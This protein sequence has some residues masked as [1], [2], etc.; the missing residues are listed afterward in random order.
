MPEPELF[1]L[2][3]R[4]LNGAGIRVAQPEAEMGANPPLFEVPPGA[5]G[6]LRVAYAKHAGDPAWT[7]FIRRIEAESPKFAQNWAA[8]DVAPPG[9]YSKALRHPGLGEFMA[10]TTTFAVQSIPGTRMTVYTPADPVSRITMERLAAGEADD[11]HF[12]CW[13]DH[14]PER[15]VVSA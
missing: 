6:Q 2:F 5:V 3:A 9:S 7:R 1:L 12:A 13:P 11:A 15:I 8:Q 14:R 4:P 10:V